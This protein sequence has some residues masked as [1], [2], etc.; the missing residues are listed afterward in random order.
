MIKIIYHKR[1]GTIKFVPL[2]SLCLRVR[3]FFLNRQYFDQLHQ[4][5]IQRSFFFFGAGEG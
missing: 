1:K 5:L 2:L 3:S 4:L